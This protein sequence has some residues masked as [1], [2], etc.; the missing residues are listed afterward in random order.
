MHN[1][2]NGAAKVLVLYQVVNSIGDKDQFNAFEIPQPSGGIKLS[3]VKQHCHA[4][5]NLSKS[6]SV[7][8]QWRV[9]VDDRVPANTAFTSKPRQKYSWW[10][11]Q[12]DSAPLPVKEVT[13]TEISQILAPPQKINSAPVPEDSVTKAASGAMR[14]LGKAM[15]KVAATVEGTNTNSATDAYFPRVSILVFKLLDLGKIYDSFSKQSDYRPSHSQGKESNYSNSSARQ[16]TGRTNAVSR[17][18]PINTTSATHRSTVASIPKKQDSLLN[19]NEPASQTSNTQHRIPYGTTTVRAPAAPAET[20]VEKLSREYKEKQQGQDL[21]WDDIDQRYVSPDSKGGESS[22]PINKTPTRPTAHGTKPTKNVGISLDPSNAVGKSA[23]VASAMQAR[24]D[25]MEKNKQKAL[26]EIRERKMKEKNGVAEEDQFRQKLDPTI[27][28]WSED[29]G[30]KKQLSALL[31][32][33]HTILWPGAKWTPVNLGD[34]LDKKKCIRAFHKATRIVHPDKTTNLDA[35]KR[36]LA[37][38]IFDALK[39]A[40]S[41]SENT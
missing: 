15:N 38:R 29:F 16:P 10:D 39:Q 24:C 13:F 36:F 19:F 3:T 14:S 21:V 6:G 22:K 37:K 7:G 35:E 4:V 1:G 26:D 12:D 40:K 8:Y 31:A 27:K 30:K 28:S 11:I 25:E 17:S 20:R 9:R 2:G 33:L 5:R 23:H 18:T 34:L 32:S 41:A